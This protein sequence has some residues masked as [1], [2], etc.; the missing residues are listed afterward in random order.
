MLGKV[1]N[2][3]YNKNSQ[4]KFPLKGTIFLWT[5][6]MLRKIQN[7]NQNIKLVPCNKCGRTFAPDRVGKH[8]KVCKGPEVKHVPTISEKYEIKQATKPKMGYGVG[9]KNEAVIPK[10]K[11][12][13]N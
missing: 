8:Q 1:S 3:R 11:A 2:R 10:W 6:Y 4:S 12:Q 5:W 9:K 7:S 13:S